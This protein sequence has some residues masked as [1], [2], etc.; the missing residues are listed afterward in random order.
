[1][2]TLRTIAILRGY[3]PE[4]ACH[5]AQRAWNAGFDLVE[6]PVQD[7]AGW[8]ALEAV[9]ELSRSGF[10]GAGTVLAPSEVVR[11]RQLGCAVTISPGLDQEL[12]TAAFEQ[13]VTPLPGVLT[14]TEVMAAVRLGVHTVKLFPASLGGSRYLHALRAPFPDLGFVA[15]GGVD[16]DNAFRFV[17]S[18]AAGVAFGSSLEDVLARGDCREFVS[19]LHDALERHWNQTSCRADQ[20]SNSGP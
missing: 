15:V 9:A 11:A 16:A 4:V 19:A 5:L 8:Q 7:E 2:T 1:M 3:R 20:P 13:G 10:L 6:I 12:V 14:P 17:E 18:G